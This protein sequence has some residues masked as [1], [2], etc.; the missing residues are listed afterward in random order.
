M[1]CVRSD[2]S[3]YFTDPWYGRMP[4]Y[5]VERPRQLGF[6]GVYR[7]RAG[8]R[9]A[10]APRR[11]LPVRPAERALLL[12]DEQ[13]LYV[14]D[15]A[16]GADPRLRREARRHA[17]RSARPRVRERH[18]LRARA[19]RPRRHE[20]RP[21]RQRLGDRAGRRL[22][23][24]AGG[25]ASRQGA[26][27]PSSPPTSPGAARTSARS[28][29]ARRTRSMRCR[30]RSG[31]GRSPTCAARRAASSASAASSPRRSPP[32]ASATDAGGR[33]DAS[34]PAPLRARSSRT[35]RTTW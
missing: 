35:C 32:P 9:R 3:I 12:P 29:S 19:G 8:P 23:L 26:A 25:R 10:A 21:A 1:S 22:G 5:G 13:R 4:V 20:M 16:A 6:Q 2:G 24:F 11:P 28:S 17:R 7:V 33:Q 30:P 15:T 18:P 27:C 14:N 34:R 31:R